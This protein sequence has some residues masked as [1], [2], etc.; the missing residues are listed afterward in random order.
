MENYKKLLK[1]IREDLG[2]KEDTLCS[3][4]GGLN[5][6]KM[7]VPSKAIYKFNTIPTK[8]LA[9]FFSD[10]EKPI[11]KFMWNCKGL[12]ISKAFLKKKNEVGGL[13]LDNFETYYKI[14]VITTVWN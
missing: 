10:M 2:K 7:S 13:T 12:W 9:A 5:I 8:I 14:V 6:V 4:T 11:L 3:W 1:E